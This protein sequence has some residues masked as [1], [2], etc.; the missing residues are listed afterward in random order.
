MPGIPA[1]PVDTT[2]EADRVQVNLLRAASVARRLQIALSLSATVIS[3][4]RRALERTDSRASKQERDL[5]FVALH[6][7]PAL[8][9]GLRADLAQRELDRRERA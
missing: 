9:A 2:A 6:Y 1:R 7:G 4:A 5:R 3:A 8:A